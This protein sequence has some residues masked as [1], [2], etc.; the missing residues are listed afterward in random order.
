MP[1]IRS[2]NVYQAIKIND[3]KSWDDV[4]ILRKIFPKENE[5]SKKNKSYNKNIAHV[6]LYLAE[7]DL[8]EDEDVKKKKLNEDIDIGIDIN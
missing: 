8:E 3:I 4:E 1:V 6:D 7:E 5:P 2:I